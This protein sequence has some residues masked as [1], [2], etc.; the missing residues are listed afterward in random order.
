MTLIPVGDGL[1]SL[2]VL[3]QR[4]RWIKCPLC[5]DEVNRLRPCKFWAPIETSS[6]V[7][8]EC[9]ETVKGLTYLAATYPIPGVD[10]ERSLLPP[11]DRL[12][13]KYFS[14]R[15]YKA[16]VSLG[17]WGF[18]VWPETSRLSV[19]EDRKTPDQKKQYDNCYQVWFALKKQFDHGAVDDVVETK[20]GGWKI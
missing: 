9:A 1:K 5:D 18:V 20:K 12:P 4:I 16:R 10:V 6:N 3:E 13:E 14:E 17:G 2:K 11:Y 7:C 15:S 19:L 8:I